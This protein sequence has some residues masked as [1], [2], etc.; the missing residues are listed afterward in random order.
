MPAATA[1]SPASADARDLL[2]FRCG[3]GAYAVDI[4]FVREIRSWTRPTP[5]PHS[6]C[7]M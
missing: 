7:F 3:G 1:P 6:P 2:T 5:L 4:M